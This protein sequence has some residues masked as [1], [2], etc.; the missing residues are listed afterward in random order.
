MAGI[1]LTT[2]STTTVELEANKYVRWKDVSLHP[3][4]KATKAWAQEI[5]GTH[6]KY[7]VDGEWLDKTTIDGATHFD[8]SALTPGDYIKVS[9]ASHN[10][11]KHAYYRIESVNGG[12]EITRVKESTVIE[13]MEQPDELDELKNDL[14]DQ[15]QQCDD[16]DTLEAISEEL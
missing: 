4:K 1:S 16:R 15:I 6:E 10:N 13:A 12:L 7:G 3:N 8:V 2:G 9:G 5:T 11:K 14:M